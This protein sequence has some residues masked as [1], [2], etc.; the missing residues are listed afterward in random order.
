MYEVNI[1]PVERVVRGAVGLGVLSLAFWGPR[2]AWGYLGLLLLATAVFGW[3][4]PYTLLGIN[5][6][7]KKPAA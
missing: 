3:C 4:P 7:R 6:C 5:T 2:S 1:H